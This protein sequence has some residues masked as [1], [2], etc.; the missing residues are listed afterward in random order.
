MGW[1]GWSSTTK[2]GV[3]KIYY[4]PVNIEA[5][6]FSL[7]LNGGIANLSSNTPSSIIV[8]ET[9]ITL[10]IPINGQA[11]GEEI[12]SLSTVG[13]VYMISPEMLF[14]HHY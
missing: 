13:I 4:S 8:S 2:N 10:E 7:S 3:V 5:N 6:D 11:N 9:K 14:P 1:P 12:L